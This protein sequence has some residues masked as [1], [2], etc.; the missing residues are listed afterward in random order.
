MTPSSIRSFTL[1]DLPDLDEVVLSALSLF[2]QEKIPPLKITYKR[3]LVVGSGNAAATGKIIFEESDAIFADESSFEKK[4]QNIPAIDGV[5][6]ISASGGKHAP[7]IAD[8]CRKKGK[9]ITLLTNNPSAPA[10]EFV[11]EV[12]YFPK[13]REPYSYNTSTYLGMILSKTKE[14]PMEILIFIK[15]LIEPKDYSI[16][17]RYTKYY[18]FVPENL[19]GIIKMLH[20]KFTELFGR[21]IARDIETFEFSKHATTIV[22]A[23]ELFV[24]FGRQESS[25]SANHISIP[26]PK[27][28]NYGAMMAVSYYIIGKIQRNHP[29]WFKQN[30]VSYCERAT[31]TFKQEV[32]PIVD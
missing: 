24:S 32:K 3:P 15:E 27:N 30:I 11:D 25:Y 22:P 26:L 4:L 8:I 5:I 29:P 2:S 31:K 16:F 18:F 9:K 17:S 6:L 21:N 12:Y 23:D 1:Q 13:N 7:I 20:A 19:H 10:K 28:A 14:N